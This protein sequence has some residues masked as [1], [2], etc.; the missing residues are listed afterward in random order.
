MGEVMSIGVLAS[1]ATALARPAQRLRWILNAALCLGLVIMSRSGT[2][3]LAIGLIF[4]ATAGLSLLRRGPVIGVV[5]VFGLG[6]V[7]FGAVAAQ[8]LAPG[9]FLAMLGKDP[10][11]TGRTD[12]WAAILRQASDRPWLGFGYAAFWEKTSAPAAFVRAETGWMVPSAHNGWLDMLVQL[13]A[14]GVALCALLL[15]AAYVLAL[16]RA[17]NGRDGDW[18]AIYLSIFLITSV[19]ESVLMQRNSLA[20]TLCIATLTKVLSEGRVGRGGGDLASDAEGE[21]YALWPPDPAEGF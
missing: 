10:T 2:A 11:L 12:I 4:G 19:S 21:V 20:W 3:L 8:M 15:A 18:A 7:A 17:L 6:T 13:G 14:V 16:V 1:T 9:V 5:T